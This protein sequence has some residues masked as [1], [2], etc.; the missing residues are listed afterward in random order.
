MVKIVVLK[1]EGGSK[2]GEA[3]KKK[4]RLS[5]LDMELSRIEEA[6]L[7]EWMIKCQV[8]SPP[9]ITV[10]CWMFDKLCIKCW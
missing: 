2:G 4:K 1:E 5:H 7:F 8:L 3:A 6:K 10:L 9:Q